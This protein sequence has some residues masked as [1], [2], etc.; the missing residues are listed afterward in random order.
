MFRLLTRG[1]DAGCALSANRAIHDAVTGGILRNI[2][3]LAPGPEIAHAA[4][5]LRDLKG[6]DFGLHSCLTSEWHTPLFHPVAPAEKVP[7]L[8]DARGAF[9][10]DNAKLHA[11]K[12]PTEQV[13]IEWQAQ[14]D[15]LRSL[16]LDIAYCD[17]HMG[18]TWMYDYADALQDFA[19]RN[20]IL[21]RLDVAVLPKVEDAFD[22][23][24]HASRLLAQ[25]KQAEPGGTYL[26]VGHPVY[27]DA[28]MHAFEGVYRSG[29]ACGRDR[30]GQRLEFMR[31]DVVTWVRNH[32]VTLIRYSEL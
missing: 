27:N 13:V 8:F 4:E 12:V 30:D 32:N 26:D 29:E 24:D 15:R 11:A 17:A 18:V 20:G 25:L 28:E 22:E 3:C 31:E 2:S 10:Q 5:H 6:V 21:C 16:G 14:L 9:P 1:D 23:F 7:A 19:Q